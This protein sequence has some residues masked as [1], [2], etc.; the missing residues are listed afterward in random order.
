[1]SALTAEQR[2]DLA[3]E[4]LPVAAR[5]VCLV[6]G[7]GDTR[8]IQQA[9]AR[10]SAAEV[11]ALA[12]GLAALA[13]PD[14]PVAE[15]LAWVTFDEHSQPAA[16]VRVLGTVR[17]LA[18]CSETLPN[19]QERAASIVEDTAELVRH[20]LTRERIAERLGISWNAVSKAHSRRSHP[21]PELAA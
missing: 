17:D 2:G 10:L 6:H 20:G 9:F 7:D 12:V 4:L 15:A 5:F 14:Q 21:V 16:P 11:F 13:D 3:E 8:D 1:M 18:A 19:H